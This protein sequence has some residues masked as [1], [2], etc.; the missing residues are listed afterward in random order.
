[1]WEELKNHY[2]IDAGGS[3]IHVVARR[4][5]NK[6]LQ[7]DGHYSLYFYS[8]TYFGDYIKIYD[9]MSAACLTV[10]N[11]QNPKQYV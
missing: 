8:L 3:S 5:S 9:S 10:G 4:L 1:M 2:C 7:S 6:C 11:V